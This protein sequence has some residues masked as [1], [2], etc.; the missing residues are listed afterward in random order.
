MFGKGG[1][2]SLENGQHGSDYYGDTN[3]HTG[4]WGRIYC[5]TACGF[6]TLTSGVFADGTAVM[7][8]TLS[9]ITLVAGQEIRGLFTAITLSSGKVIAYK[10]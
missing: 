3:A 8:G 9:G 2:E 4:T 6:T 7:T 1:L 10:V 5:V